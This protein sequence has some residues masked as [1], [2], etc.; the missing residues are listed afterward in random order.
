MKQLQGKSTGEN[1]YCNIQTNSKVTFLESGV[2]LRICCAVLVDA[3]K[4]KALIY[5]LE[6][7]ALKLLEVTKQVRP[8]K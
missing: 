2:C 3:I 1:C 6:S 7:L 4:I 8:I 5:F